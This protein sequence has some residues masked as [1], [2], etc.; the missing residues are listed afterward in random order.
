MGTSSVKH[1]PQVKNWKKVASALAAS[2]RQSAPIVNQTIRIVLPMMPLGQS[3]APAYYAVSMGIRFGLEVQERG[4]ENALEK[5]GIRITE[6]LLVPRVSDAL[7]DRI[8]DKLPAGNVNSPIGRLAQ[9]AFK[10]T[11]GS[12]LLKGV[13]A[14][15]EEE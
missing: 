13:R 5:E 14:M 9:S 8:S 7:W 3:V 12:I 6:E 2:T 11:V 15:T 10:K 4:L 1:R